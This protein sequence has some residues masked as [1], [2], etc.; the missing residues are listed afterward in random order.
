MLIQAGLLP[1]GMMPAMLPSYKEHA[2][3]GQPSW[4]EPACQALQLPQP[5][6]GGYISSLCSLSTT[7]CYVYLQL[8]FLLHSISLCILSNVLALGGPAASPCPFARA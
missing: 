8:R 5:M 4:E 7:F 3:G 6:F 1:A 2:M